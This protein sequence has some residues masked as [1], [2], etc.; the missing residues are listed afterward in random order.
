ME[1]CR[2]LLAELIPAALRVLP[3]EVQWPEDASTVRMAVEQLEKQ[4]GEQAELDIARMNGQ[5][6]EG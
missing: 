5:T 6:E 2:G 4:K 3:R 1:K